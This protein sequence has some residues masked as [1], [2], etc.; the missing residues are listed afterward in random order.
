MEFLTRHEIDYTIESCN[1]EDIFNYNERA[2]LAAMREIY[3]TE[4][5][6]CRCQ[7]CIEDVYALA[8]NSLPTRYVQESRVGTYE[9]SSHFIPDAE[10]RDKVKAALSKVARNPSH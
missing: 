10:I 3:A 8:L 2:V 9:R 6:H 7:L 1:L 5:S 4:A